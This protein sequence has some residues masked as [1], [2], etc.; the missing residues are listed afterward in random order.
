MVRNGYE[1][2]H[3]C[4]IRQERITGVIPFGSLWVCKYCSGELNAAIDSSMPLIVDPK[5]TS[6]VTINPSGKPTTT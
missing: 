6:P 3:D 5:V 4:P 2:V 1:I